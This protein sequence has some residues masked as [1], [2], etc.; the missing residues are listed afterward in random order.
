[1]ADR[2]GRAVE[3]AFATAEAASEPPPLPDTVAQACQTLV[4]TGAETCRLV[5]LTL[6]SATAVDP[7]VRPD[8][9]QASAGGID[10]RS[11]YK[12]AVRPVLLAAAARRSAP[13]QPSQ[14]PFVSN[15]FREPSIDPDWVSK[16]TTRLAGAADLLAIVSHV[17]A[18]P[19]EAAAV[20]DHLA[21][22]ELALLE[23][24]V[25]IYRIPLRLSTRVVADLLDRWLAGDAGGRRHEGVSIAL[26]RFAG[27]HL[28]AGWDSVE[29]HH[30]NDPTPYDAI[31]K[32]DGVVRAIGEVKAQ[33]ITLEHLRQLAGQMG[34][35]RARRG[36][37]FT[38][39]SWLPNRGSAEHQGLLD[40]L[41]D[42]DGLGRRIDILDAMETVRHWLPLMDQDDNALPD[43]IRGLGQ[44]LDDHALAGDRR[45][46]A[47][48]LEEL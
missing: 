1:M 9:I 8:R 20:L 21:I 14:D 40:F 24:A 41:R 34:E 48:R 30:V 10:F 22:H 3:H 23:K 19:G 5:A 35:H 15:P 25:V 47:H 42:Q 32:S 39:A 11:L 43:F 37:L 29:S 27:L 13:W 4:M 44:E 36:Y 38:R 46:L 45:A 18:N 12:E 7:Q 17:A 6:M 16:R 2:M 31:C 28:R 33:P 26:L